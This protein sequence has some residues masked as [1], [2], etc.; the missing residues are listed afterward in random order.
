ME[1]SLPEEID[2]TFFDKKLDV[3]ELKISLNVSFTWKFLSHDIHQGIFNAQSS[4][5]L[6]SIRRLTN[7]TQS[8]N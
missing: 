7:I 5:L 8:H 3:A 6:L 4:P 1:N 2:Q